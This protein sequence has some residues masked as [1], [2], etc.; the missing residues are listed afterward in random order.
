MAVKC[1]CGGEYE[2]HEEW[3]SH[4]RRGI[5]IPRRLRRNMYE[6]AEKQ[7][8]ALFAYAEK[9]RVIENGAKSSFKRK[10]ITL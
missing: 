10:D 5:P 1:A 7:Q 2:D 9:H 4:I 6:E 3:M 8:R